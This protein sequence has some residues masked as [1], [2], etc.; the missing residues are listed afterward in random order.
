MTLL[1]YARERG[2]ETVLTHTTT[3]LGDVLHERMIALPDDARSL[4]DVVAVAEAQAPLWVLS[5]AAGLGP[6]ERER[7]FGLLRVTSMVRSSKVGLEPWLAP[8]HDRIRETIVGRMTPEK[9]AG[10]HQRIA[11]ALERWEGARVDALARH[12]LGA[13]DRVRARRYLIRAAEGAAEKLAFD[14]AAELYG[15]AIDLTTDENSLVVELWGKCATRTTGHAT[16][17]VSE[18]V[19][20]TWPNLPAVPVA[21]AQTLRRYGRVCSH[22]RRLS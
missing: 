11:D 13:N 10:T 17:R 2:A 15:E 9:L 6:D 7:A 5:T 8:Y 18:V 22:R 16:V 19:D 12:W 1:R 20:R 4:L 21:I 14:R 3:T